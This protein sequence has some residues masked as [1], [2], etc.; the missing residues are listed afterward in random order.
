[1]KELRIGFV[2]AGGMG[3][4][5]MKEIVKR[6]DVH[7]EMLYEINTGRGEKVLQD[8]SLDKKILVDDFQLI[9]DNPDIDIVWLVS[10]NGFHGSQSIS[11]MKA[12]KHV[13]C[14]KPCATDFEDYVQQIE[15][16]KKNPDL[17]TFVNYLMIFDPMQNRLKKMIA[18]NEFGRITQIQINYRY[19]I[20]TAGAMSWKLKKG[21][22]G[23]SIGM[24]TVHSLSA[25]INVMSP[26][27]HPVAVYATNLESQI[28]GFE[29]EPIY[30]ILIRFN[31][32]TTGFCFGDIETSKGLDFYHNISGTEGGFVFD[33]QQELKNKVRY[34]SDK[35]TQGKWIWPLD[36]EKCRREGFESSAWETGTALTDS[37]EAAELRLTECIEHFIRSVKNNEKSDLSF[38][39]SSIVAQVGWAAQMS[40]ATGKE[41]PLPLDNKKAGDFFN[42]SE[43]EYKG[44]EK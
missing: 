14:E 21:I 26:Q 15:I 42:K 32:G 33:N 8:L 41:I 16:E 10:P 20:N 6:E 25:I 5:Q 43:T 19:P 4:A 17:K 31:N 39:N 37:P 35:K 40:A 12:G 3:S 22:M 9:L 2:G 30:N 27:A 29:A 7:I 18:R 38:E 11:A 28:N 34:C 13:F 36:S 44:K 24:G 23:D 1:M